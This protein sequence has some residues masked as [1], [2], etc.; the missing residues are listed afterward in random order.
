MA[1]NEVLELARIRL[2][3]DLS[4]RALGEAIGL[5]ERTITRILTTPNPRLYDRTLF[6]IRR[7]LDRIR[8]QQAVPASRRKAG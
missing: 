7:Y 5:P 8:E 1:M 6:K 2:E 4:Y 3:E